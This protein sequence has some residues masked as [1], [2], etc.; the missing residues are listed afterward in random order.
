MTIDLNRAATLLDVMQ[1]CATV[2]P[3]FT[4]IAGRA[5]D[6]LK[7]MNAEILEESRKKAEAEKAKANE[8]A[9]RKTDEVAR[10]EGRDPPRPD[11][12]RRIFPE[13]SGVREEHD[14]PPVQRRV[15]P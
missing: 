7:A 2:G 8:E 12:N 1:K 3:M 13:N 15:V 6:E 5:G 4:A 14:P 10:R 9:A 11:P